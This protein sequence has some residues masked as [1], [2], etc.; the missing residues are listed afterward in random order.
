[1]TLRD[2]YC[3]A[4]AAAIACGLTVVSSYAQQRDGGLLPPGETG[5]VTVTGCLLRGNQITGGDAAKYVLANPRKAPAT[6]TGQSCTAEPGANAVQL[7]NP[8]RARIS[9]TMLGRWVEI[10]GRLERETAGQ[11]KSLRELDVE[12]VRLLAAS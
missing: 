5:L 4:T 11:S 7:D 9:D 8:D 6:P 1:M 2:V 3:G 12:H 10:T